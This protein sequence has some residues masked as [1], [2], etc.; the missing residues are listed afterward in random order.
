[1]ATAGKGLPF[2]GKMHGFLDR[3]LHP[4]VNKVGN[5]TAAID[6]KSRAYYCVNGTATPLTVGAASTDNLLNCVGLNAKPGDIIRILTTANGIKEFE[7]TVDEAPDANSATL[8]GYLSANLAAGDTFHLLR[9]IHELVSSDGATLA[10]VI[11]PPIQYNR[12]SA[13]VTTATTVLEDLD[14]PT[15]SRALPVVIHSIDGAPI[16][17][18]AGD[19]SV[20]TSHVNDSMS[21][22]DGTT[23]VGVTASN[24]FKTSDA[25]VLSRLTNAVSVN[26]V[27]TTPLGAGATY[28]GTADD[29]LQYACAIVSVVVDRAGTLFLESSQDGLV[30]DH[31]Q[32]YAITVTTPGVAEGQ[33]FQAM[34]E[35]R[36][37]RVRYTNGGTIQGTFKIQ[38]ILNHSVGVGEV[39]AVAQALLANTDALVTKGVIYGL[40]TGGGG[41]YVAVKVTPSGAL[42]VEA[43]TAQLPTVLGQTT[44]AGSTSVTIASDQTPI[45]AKGVLLDVASNSSTTPLAGGATFTGAAIDT[46]GYSSISLIIASD[47]ASA[48]NGVIIEYSGDGVNWEEGTVGT[49]TPGAAPNAG[50]VFGGGL[51]AKY[52]R[53]VFI[54]GASAQASFR[55][56]TTLR[57]TP[58]VADLIDMEMVIGSN[59][60]GIV[61]KS[62]ITGKTTAGGGAFVDVKVNPSGTLTVDASNS[63]GLT[64]TFTANAGTNL[65]TSALAL[66]TTQV[67]NGVLI[68]AVT[69]AA[70]ATDTASS[71]LNGRLQR[72]AQRLTSI[73]AVLPSAIGQQLKA[74]SLS[75]TMA[76]D[77]GSLAV[78]Q[79]A[80][81]PTYAESLT[82][83]NTGVTT[84]NAPAGAKGC[85]IITPLT[86][87]V[88]L[89]VTLDGTTTPT[90]TVGGVGMEIQPGRAEDY[91][92]VGN[93]QAI[94]QTVATAQ[95][96]SVHWY[97]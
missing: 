81:T 22:G 97:T 54:N 91:K 68:G 44:M 32:S 93:L 64:G 31:V 74:N 40:T 26:N 60:H 52:A 10:T 85:K 30:W 88:N 46:S 62:V 58:M 59:T 16:I 38:T 6:V 63:T 48:A 2:I 13:G 84:L 66:E 80:Q 23:L 94:C 25:S 55:M 1:M 41:G 18:N 28:T 47:V 78:A 33:F 89:H 83:A 37:F 51:R 17:V 39:Q 34:K 75:V 4:T 19:L 73:I 96:I 42:T 12:K 77:Q 21:I 86:N 7:I 67:A 9:P 72:I 15:S 35:A 27:T 87:T 65:N 36:Y 71:G 61:T 57:T 69:E 90:T 70:P 53:V 95:K 3:V 76:S 43:T 56:Y 49:Y 24:E 11:S 20:S 45:A 14:T 50:Q 29:L 8:A 92:G 79:A 82:V 5:S